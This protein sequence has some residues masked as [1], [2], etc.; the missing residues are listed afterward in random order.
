MEIVVRVIAISMILMLQTGV[1]MV[2]S[3]SDAAADGSTSMP[4]PSVVPI[5]RTRVLACSG[6][7]GPSHPAADGQRSVTDTRSR[8]VNSAHSQTLQYDLLG[9]VVQG[10]GFYGND[11]CSYDAVG[12]RLTR[13]LGTTSTT[14]AYA[15]NSNRLTGVTSGGSTRAY[16]YDADG[17]VITVKVGSKTQAAH[18]FNNNGRMATAS[19]A[20]CTYD[21]FGARVIEAVTGGATTH[22]IFG[23][24]GALLAEDNATGQVQRSYVYQKGNAALFR[25]EIQNG[26]DPDLKEFARRTLPKIE[27]H[28][29][30]VLTLAM[31]GEFHTSAS[32]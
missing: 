9:R 23:P 30:R 3:S 29:Q 8:R 6:T 19:S 11:N 24:K 12:N 21:A 26:T 7:A 13:T 1:V 18:T 31:S 15:A 14:Y 10:T 4:K 22:F 32:E 17:N 27:D 25:Y 28:L 20:S 2:A 5:D 16:G